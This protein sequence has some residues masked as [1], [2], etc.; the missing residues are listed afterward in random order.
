MPHYSWSKPEQG[1]AIQRPLL[2]LSINPVPIYR[3]PGIRP[4]STVVTT[5]NTNHL[6]AA[7]P[8]AVAPA[9]AGK[10]ATAA[11][12]VKLTQHTESD[13]WLSMGLAFY[14]SVLPLTKQLVSRGKLGA[15]SRG[16][17]WCKVV[18]W[19]GCRPC[20]LSFKRTGPCLPTLPCLPNQAR[21]LVK[22]TGPCL[23]ALPLAPSLVLT[24]PAA[25]SPAAGVPVRLAVE[26]RAAGPARAA[27]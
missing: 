22:H 8:V 23:P 19:P 17:R 24:Y 1:C 18:C 3:S 21:L 25:P 11:T 5:P 26:P 13:A 15:A 9:A 7:F 12:L 4:P 10:Y 2:L 27:H 6:Q 16:E 20:L 14:L